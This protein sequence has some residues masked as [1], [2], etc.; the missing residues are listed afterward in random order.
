MNWLRRRYGAGPLHLLALPACLAF[1]GYMVYTVLPAPLSIRILIW[2]AGAA[3]AHDLLLW[4]LY[5]IADRSA[6]RLHR[7]HPDR[8]P[9]IPWINYLRVPAVLS[10]VMLAISFPL[11]LR[12]AEPTYRAATGLSESPYLSRW[13]I[14]SGAAFAASAVLYALRLAGLRRRRPGAG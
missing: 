1:S 5:A 12:L 7:R 9:A 8:L 10:A 4:P 3:V 11:V 2:F 14:L 6:V 13:L